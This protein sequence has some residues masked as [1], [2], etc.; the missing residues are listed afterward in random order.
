MYR[1]NDK[2]LLNACRVILEFRGNNLRQILP[3]AARA[4]QIISV[5]RLHRGPKWET[6]FQTPYDFCE[7]IEVGVVGH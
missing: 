3:E 5:A 7:R 6:H 1:K 4:H 2:K